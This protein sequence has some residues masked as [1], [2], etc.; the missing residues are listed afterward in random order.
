[1]STKD[2]DALIELVDRAC[3][4]QAEAVSPDDGGAVLVCSVGPDPFGDSL[5]GQ[6]C[7]CERDIIWRPHAD[8]IKTKVCIICAF[9]LMRGGQA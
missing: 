2:T 4:E 5:S 7:H 3:A 1:M 6:C 9:D 8:H